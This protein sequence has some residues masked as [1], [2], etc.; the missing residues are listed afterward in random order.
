MQGN[1][2]IAHRK[3]LL[4]RTIMKLAT[5]CAQHEDRFYNTPSVCGNEY[6]VQIPQHVE[7]PY[8]DF[9]QE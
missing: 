7:K 3:L 9:T 1:G 4:P 6:K 2:S 8:A 5:P